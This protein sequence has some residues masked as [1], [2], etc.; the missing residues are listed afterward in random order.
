MKKTAL[1]IAA[2]LLFTAAPEL[3]AQDHVEVG[4]FADYVRLHHADDANFWGVGGRV[5]FNIAPHVQLEAD[6][7][8]DFE[9]QFTNTFNNGGTTTFTQ[10]NGLRLLH[11]SFGPKIQTN[12]GPVRA[13]VF[14]KGGFLNFSVSGANPANGFN[15]TFAN[16][17]TGDTNGVFYPGG[18]VEFFAGPIGLRLEAGDL[19]Y[20][21]RGA[22]H[23]L[24]VTFGPTFRF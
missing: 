17:G 12:L 4:A 6:M 10:S 16:F 7:A 23:N 19:M 8:Y 18:G 1:L 9:R 15:N 11:G 13:F 24:S 21:D 5:G 22:N 3:L 14:A 2:A 20:F